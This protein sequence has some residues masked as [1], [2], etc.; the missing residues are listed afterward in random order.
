MMRDG[1]CGMPEGEGVNATSVGAGVLLWEAGLA[2]RERPN[3][4]GRV[5]RWK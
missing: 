5:A 3:A 1:V 2:Y 4:G